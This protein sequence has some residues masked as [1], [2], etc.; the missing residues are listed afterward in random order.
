MFDPSYRTPQ[1]KVYPGHVIP[2]NAVGLFINARTG[3]GCYNHFMSAE[4][5]LALL[6][7][8]EAEKETLIRIA[9][10]N[11]MRDSVGTPAPNFDT[12]GVL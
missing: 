10:N 12:G 6:A 3:P 4:N 2:W 8:L 5:A 11:D 9:A 7:Q 1:L